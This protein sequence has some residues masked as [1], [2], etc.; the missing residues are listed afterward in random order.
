MKKFILRLLGIKQ[1]DV[2]L[3]DSNGNLQLGTSKTINGR[4]IVENHG[5][6]IVLQDDGRVRG[7]YYYEKWE[8]L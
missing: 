2:L 1:P 7:S 8:E 6:I 5:G 3:I 4:R